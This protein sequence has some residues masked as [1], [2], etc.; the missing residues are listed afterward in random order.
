MAR[1]P[2]VEFIR[3][4]VK[5]GEWRECQIAIDGVLGLPFSVHES[6]WRM[7]RTDAERNEMLTRQAIAMLQDYG[8]ARHQA[9]Q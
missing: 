4:G 8:D 3:Y 9:V 6:D 5:Q 1:G 2:K 7:Y